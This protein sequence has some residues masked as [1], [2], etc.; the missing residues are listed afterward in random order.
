MDQ[1][2]IGAFLKEL[3]KEKALT[4][5]QL[6][7]KFGVS[8]R[9]VSRWE[10]GNNMPDISLLVELADF[11]DVDIRDII[12]GERKSEDMNKEMKDT[13]VKVAEYTDAEKEKILKTLSVN[14]IICCA[15]F[16]AITVMMTVNNMYPEP[17][18][19]EILYFLPYLGF[20]IMLSSIINIMQIRGSMSKN[21][22]RKIRRIG[23]PIALAVMLACMVGV[24]L[25]ISSFFN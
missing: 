5:E 11:Y 8:G 23:I 24:M 1:V 2:R 17:V 10:N 9:T 6:A 13:L 19:G 18:F 15:A 12:D 21:R 25:L 4:Q 3:R 20:G 7:E 16:L 14:I 22:L